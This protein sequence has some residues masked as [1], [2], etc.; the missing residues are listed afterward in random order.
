MPNSVTCSMKDDTITLKY[1]TVVHFAA[2]DALRGQV[3]RI[4]H[5]SIDILTKCVADLKAQFKDI[6]GKTIKLKELTNRDSLEVIAATNLSPR[7]V[8]Y[9][10]RQVA[11]Q[12]V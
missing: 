11:L 9:Y 8:A 5:E 12:V 4:K 10:R 3:D 6:T 2:E 7:R 1:I